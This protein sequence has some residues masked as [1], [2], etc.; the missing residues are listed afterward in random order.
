MQTATDSVGVS[1]RP[2]SCEYG[3]RSDG[4]VAQPNPGRMGSAVVKIAD[5]VAQNLR[6]SA[7]KRLQQ[8]SAIL[9]FAAIGT[10]SGQVDGGVQLPSACAL[11]AAQFKRL[12]KARFYFLD[13]GWALAGKSRMPMAVTRRMNAPP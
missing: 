4:Q 13:V 10:Q 7:S 11:L 9:R 1:L 6:S 12:R 8:C 3:A 5:H 2:E